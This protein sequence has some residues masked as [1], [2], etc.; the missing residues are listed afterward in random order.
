MQILVDAINEVYHRGVVF[1]YAGQGLVSWIIQRQE[2]VATLTTEA[3]TIAASEAGSHLRLASP[4]F[5]N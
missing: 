4:I 3:E 2:T 1:T 5:K